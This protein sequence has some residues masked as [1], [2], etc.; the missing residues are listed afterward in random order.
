ML[1][2]GGGVGAVSDAA[3]AH[4]TG[5][6]LESREIGRESGDW[7]SC[8]ESSEAI[9]CVESL[10]DKELCGRLGPA[11]GAGRRRASNTAVDE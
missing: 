7:L 9:D 11:A 6:V 1:G 8:P 10:G 5:I 3:A 2:R 4:S